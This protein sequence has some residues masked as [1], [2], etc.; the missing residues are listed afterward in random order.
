[1][2]LRPMN[3]ERAR[4]LPPTLGDLLPQDHPARFVAAFVDALG[5]DVWAGMEIDVDGDPVGAPAYHPWALFSVW[6][7]GFIAGVRSCRKLVRRRHAEVRFPS[8]G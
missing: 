5:R 2:P 6:L 8:F 7:Y 3:R 1:M 4:L